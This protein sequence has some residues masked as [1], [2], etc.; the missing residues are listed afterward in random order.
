MWQV[1]MILEDLNQEDSIMSGTACS[2]LLCWF[3]ENPGHRQPYT[4]VCGCCHPSWNSDR[5]LSSGPPFLITNNPPKKLYLKLDSVY[6]K[7]HIE[8]K[9]L[10]KQGK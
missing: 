9:E 4:A 1:G 8:I 7:L 2:Q 10:Q 5:S 3:R 6:A